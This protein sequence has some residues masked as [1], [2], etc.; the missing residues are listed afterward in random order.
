MH[1]TP[2][3]HLLQVAFHGHFKREQARTLSA[4]SQKSID[5][6]DSA[7]FIQITHTISQIELTGSQLC[8]IE[9]QIAEIMKFHDA[10]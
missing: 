6:D 3:S 2:L 9:F 1:L 8:S 10:E 5:L 7:L 4:L